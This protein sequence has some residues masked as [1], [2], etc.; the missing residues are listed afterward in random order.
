[1]VIARSVAYKVWISDI[2]NGE[3]IKQEGFNPNYIVL[4]GKQISR[5]NL[6]ATVVG[7]FMSDD[8]NYGA[9]TIDDGTE[10]IRMK[11]FGPD[12][13][14][15]KKAEVGQLVRA[16]GKLKE[17]NDERYLSPDFVVEIK[18]PNWV[19]V[20]KLELGEAREIVATADSEGKPTEPTQPKLNGTPK[21]EQ[22]DT[23]KSK[24]SIVENKPE[25]KV[26]GEKPSESMPNF[27]ELIKKLDSGD[28][29]DMTEVVA[30]CKL[31]EEEAKIFI[32]D[33]LKQGE[34]Y[35]PR[36]GKLK[37]L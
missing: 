6:I 8:G 20:Q 5:V 37:V 32:I 1:M 22:E 28:G 4:D 29:A 7:K 13:I 9:I 23:A 21:T 18:D 30:E 10:T 24:E 34:I 11:A 17:Y 15:I 36:K 12:V 26:E 2:S 25:E 16:V 19:I 3:Y 31:S 14:K 27:V 35:E 33:L